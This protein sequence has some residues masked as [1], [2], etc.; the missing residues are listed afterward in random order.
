MK[1]QESAWFDQIV[2]LDLTECVW[3]CEI[4]VSI[5]EIITYC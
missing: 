2:M 1:V 5:N 3:K 4:A